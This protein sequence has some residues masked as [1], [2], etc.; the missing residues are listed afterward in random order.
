RVRE[1]YQ[2]VRSS[3][4]SRSRPEQLATQFKNFVEKHFTEHRSVWAYAKMLN[5]S[6]R[7]LSDVVKASTGRSPLEIIHDILFLEAK[8]LL[9]STDRSVSEI[10]HELRFDDQAH[11]SHFIKKRTGSTPGELRKKL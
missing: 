4:P 1:I 7:Y 5:I 3:N 10:A 2:R 6:P 11:F 9:R 8:A